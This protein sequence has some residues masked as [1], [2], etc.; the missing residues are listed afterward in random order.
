MNERVRFIG[1]YLEA[2][3]PFSAVCEQFGVS[4]KTGY[5]WV[6]RYETYGLAGLEERSRAPLSRPHAVSDEVLAE[7]LRVRE[8]HPRWGPRKLRVILQRQHPD[9]AVP[10]ASTI[11]EIL[12]KR[13]LSK[14]KRRIRRSPPYG[15]RLLSY[16]RPNAV[17]CADFKGHFPVAGERCHPLTISDGCSRYLVGCRAL[18]RTMS[19]PTRKAFEPVF[20]EYGLPDAM[21]TDNGAPFSSRAAGGL[22][23]LAVWWIRLGIL[24]ERIEPGRPDQNGRHER[25]HSTLKA[26]TV[27]PPRSSFR[28]QQR[29]FD[30]FREEYNHI[31]PHE[32]LGQ[33]VPA[34][35]YRPSQRRYPS[36]LPEPEY[37]KHFDITRADPGG[38]I[39]V[40]SKRWYISHCLGL[41]L[42][43]LEEVD[44]GRWKVYF[45]PIALGILD[46]RNANKHGGR[47]FSSLVCPDRGRK[48]PY[49]R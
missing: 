11:G 17:W 47:A 31:R 19:E 44:A 24:P 35:V 23:R 7:V 46:L 34:S 39:A 32:S 28:A 37:P 14:P 3:E 16:D 27:K 4:R 49:K 42:V 5:K 43:G 40:D 13:G 20:R 1:S 33:E 29:A 41:E 45:G 2:A 15:A 25:M 6:E 22:S 21:R 26:E 18:R 12:R 9:I 36:R 38:T 48:R 30:Q 10:A 8:K